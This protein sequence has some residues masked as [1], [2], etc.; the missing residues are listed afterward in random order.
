MK[1]TI[2]IIITA[3]LFWP[4]L[5]AYKNFNFNLKLNPILNF[6]L[7]IKAI[8][9]FF[10][11]LIG[12]FSLISIT[13]LNNV[14]YSFDLIWFLNNFICADQPIKLIIEINDLVLIIP[15]KIYCDLKNPATIKQ[16]RIDNQNKAGIY[17]IINKL[18][19]KFYIGSSSSLTN[20]L[21]KHYYSSKYLEKSS[22][23]L[24]VSAFKKYGIENFSFEILEY[25]ES[26]ALAYLLKREQYY[27]DLLK[28]AYNI[29][30]IAG[31]S[32][33]AKWSE[34][35]KAKLSDGRRK[36]KNSVLLGKTHTIETKLLMTLHNK[37]TQ[38]L[39]CYIKN[40]SE[41]KSKK[42]ELTTK[43]LKFFKK[44]N[45]MRE[46]SK[47]FKIPV[48]SIHYA[49][50]NGNFYKSTYFFSTIELDLK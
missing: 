28:P 17:R 5:I 7:Q 35:N 14:F 25:C 22:I 11:L 4:I 31:S 26:S 45:S 38:T 33:G 50:K 6:T 19:G 34:A 16:M 13:L 39:F 46:A 2:I 32:K 44:F 47:Y 29:L 3:F 27:L 41:I 1:K 42:P 8:F 9:Q 12:P 23:K 18:N 37:K 30:T 36:G 21:N 43:N 10:F 40:N 48:S 15:I 20:R 24:L 49:V